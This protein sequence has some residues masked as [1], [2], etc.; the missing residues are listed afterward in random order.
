MRTEPTSARRKFADRRDELEY[1]YH[2]LL[3]WLYER[4]GRPRARAFADRLDRLV[5]KASAGHDAIFPE[6][7]R[8]LIWEA[9]GD[10]AKAIKHR[11]NEIRLRKRLLSLAENDPHRDLLLGMYGYDDLSERLDLLAVLLHTSRNIKAG[12]PSLTHALP[13]SLKSRRGLKCTF[14]GSLT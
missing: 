6:E 12:K 8:S 3:Y 1:L 4:Q 13:V 10:L 14:A 5:A 7:C 9:R 2:K 11:R